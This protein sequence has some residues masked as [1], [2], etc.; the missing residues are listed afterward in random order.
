ML[1]DY[2]TYVSLYGQLSE[3]EFNSFEAEAESYVRHYTFN[4]VT[5]TTASVQGAIKE[6]VDFLV[7]EKAQETR[8]DS[9]RTDGRLIKA[10]SS[11]TYRVEFDTAKELSNS[12]TRRINK[13]RT[14]YEICLRWLA[15]TGM[16]YRGVDRYDYQW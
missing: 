4:R 12:E 5:E 2:Q 14:I 8:E 1:L 6:I 13:H 7:A 10:E 15:H 11:G 3:A 16:M 9:L